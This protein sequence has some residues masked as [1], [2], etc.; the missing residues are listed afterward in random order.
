M[1]L[2]KLLDRARAC[3]DHK[4]RYQTIVIPN[5]GAINRNSR[6]YTESFARSMSGGYFGRMHGQIGHSDT[7]IRSITLASHIIHRT[8]LAG[9]DLWAEYSII[10]NDHGRLLYDLLQNQ[11]FA[12]RPRGLGTVNSDGTIGNDYKLLAF[13]FI[14][15][16]EDSFS[17]QTPYDGE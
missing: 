11:D 15:V 4:T 12:L 16:E 2:Q 14:P 3:L 13:D 5:L 17:V 1:M 10:D 7:G 8:F 6:V 9:K